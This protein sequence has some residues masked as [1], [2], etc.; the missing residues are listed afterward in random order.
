M[1]EKLF[2][3]VQEPEIE[4][5]KSINTQSTNSI[6]MFSLRF[7]GSKFLMNFVYT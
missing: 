1:Q 6:A 5:Y 7:S 3:S 2:Y 4:V